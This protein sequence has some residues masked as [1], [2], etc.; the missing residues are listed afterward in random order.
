[1][2]CFV[3]IE[4][5]GG[6]TLHYLLRNNFMSHLTLTP[7]DYWT[8]NNHSSFQKEEAKYLFKFFN[9]VK[10]FGGHTTRSYL[11]YESV[12]DDCVDYITF[13]REPVSRYISHYNHQKNVM[14][15]DW[16]IESFLKEKRFDNFMTKRIAGR[17]DIDKAKQILNEKFS[18][19]GLI[20]SFDESLVLMRN[21]LPYY[22][23]N[24]NYE[25]KN[26][27]KNENYQVNPKLTDSNMLNEIK[28]RNELDIELYQFAKTSIF[29]KYQ[30]RYK[31]N[32]EDTI[33]DFQNAN[34][35]FKFNKIKHFVCILYRWLLY[36]NFE[37]VLHKRY[38]QSFGI[39]KRK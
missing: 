26:K 12:I 36:R 31:G 3:H 22:N 20:E 17:E 9:F 4:K 25:V 39:N 13:L 10:S 24:I 18:F 38:H 11:N 28:K 15:I 23:F 32:M 16:N 14:K 19:V 5:A 6:T 35:Q 7:W 2:I 1:M 34:M 8:N 21:E 33:H 37:Y 29:P 27:S 30:E